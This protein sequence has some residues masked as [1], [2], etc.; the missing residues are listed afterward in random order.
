MNN[1]AK[2]KL[3]LPAFVIAALLVI[4]G[5]ALKP[6]Q[7]VDYNEFHRQSETSPETRMAYRQSVSEI[8]YV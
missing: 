6:V 1:T 2:Q 5:C 4:S 8:R 7:L 3:G